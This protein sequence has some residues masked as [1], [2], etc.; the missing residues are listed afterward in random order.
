MRIEIEISEENAAFCDYPG[1][2]KRILREFVAEFDAF[3]CGCRAA[4]RDRNGN[5]VGRV[6]VIE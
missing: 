1:E 6:T 4:L 3:R 5:T 2:T